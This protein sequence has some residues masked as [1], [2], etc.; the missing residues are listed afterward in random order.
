LPDI[1]IRANK[2]AAAFLID[3]RA[4]ENFILRTDPYYHQNKIEGFAYL[5]KIH[6]GIVVGQLQKRGHIRWEQHRKLLDKVRDIIAE[7][8][9][10]DGYG[11]EVR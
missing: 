8:S 9:I 10:T 1:E 11:F 7:A 2:D 5:H 6:P 4:L 3:Q